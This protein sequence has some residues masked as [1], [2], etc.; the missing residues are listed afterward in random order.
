[1]EEIIKSITEAEARA[2]EI[3]AHA[4]AKAAE[5]AEQAEARAAEMDRLAEAECKEMRERLIE[6]AR[7]EAQARYEREI[8]AKRDEA[9]KYAQK[10]LGDTDRHVNDIVRRITGGSR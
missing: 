4:I 5:I 8:V 9:Q 6:A 7:I 3:K 10:C 2:A 1:M